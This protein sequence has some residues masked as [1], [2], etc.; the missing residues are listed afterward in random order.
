MS[1]P[2]DV[3]L[4]GLTGCLPPGT[5]R[6]LDL[7]KIGPSDLEQHVT[8]SARRAKPLLRTGHGRLLVSWVVEAFVFGCVLARHLSNRAATPATCHDLE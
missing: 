6:R 2:S 7:S 4:V 3:R 5:P 1:I 8:T